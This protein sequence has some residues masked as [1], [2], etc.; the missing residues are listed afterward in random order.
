MKKAFV[1]ILV[2][3]ISQNLFAETI[4]KEFNSSKIAFLELKNTAGRIDIRGTDSETS[5][6]A[7]DK[8]KVTPNC[9]IEIDSKDNALRI[10]VHDSSWIKKDNCIVNLSVTVPKKISMNIR[11]GS[12]NIQIKDT[13]GKID[14]LTG[15]SNI[16]ISA[17]APELTGRLA[18]G[19]LTIN[20]NMGN[21]Q[22]E[23]ASGN[24]KINGT[25]GKSTIRSA[26]GNVDLKGLTDNAEIVTAS[27]NI[28]VHYP[29]SFNANELSIKSAS[30][31]ATILL[32]EDSRIATDFEAGSGRLLNEVGDTENPTLKIAFRSGS[33]DLK[34]KKTK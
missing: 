2:V 25:L 17:Q 5:T 13:N 22:I 10:D 28:T 14:F 7:A 26:S 21:A 29:K 3:I 30:G 31:N 1:A 12:G 32:P 8:I 34:I 9:V 6:V 18:S 19:N 27:G 33:G 11:A 23:S 16:E 24:M 20:G 15:S 4:T